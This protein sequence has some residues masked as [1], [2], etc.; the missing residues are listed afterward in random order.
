MSHLLRRLFAWSLIAGA[1]IAC[2]WALAAEHRTIGQI[3]GTLNGEAKVWHL[4]YSDDDAS[5][6]ALSVQLDGEEPMTILGGYESLDVEFGRDANGFPAASGPGSMLI[7][8]FRIPNGADGV[9]HH[10]E[11]Q[12]VESA[13]VIYLPEVGDFGGM[14]AM[15]KGAVEIARVD[16]PVD[17]GEKFS[18]SFSGTFASM[19]A[20]GRSIE[21]I[22]GHFEVEGTRPITQP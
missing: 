6:S 20:A 1:C 22:D 19:D 7:I 13:G 17:V 2:T 14:Y 5:H 21:I 8:N 18:G 16:M 11:Q 12:G 10:L 4:I 15:E 3:T 9:T